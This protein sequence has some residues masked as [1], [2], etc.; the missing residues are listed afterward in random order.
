[1]VDASRVQPLLRDQEALTLGAQA[2]LHRDAD[3]LVEDL[4]V[5]AEL[6]ELV[7]R[8]L[9]GRDVAQDVHARRVG[10]DDEHRRALVRARVRVGDRHDD[11][12]VGDRP[13]G[14]EP[15][16]PRDHIVVAITYRARRELGRIAAGGVRLGHRKGRLQVALQQ[17][18]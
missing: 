2:V 10:R 14:S 8:V 15:L 7:L 5:P 11:E 13:V 12:E 9:H 3:V 4:S 18:V 6:P 17:R 16:V 1:M